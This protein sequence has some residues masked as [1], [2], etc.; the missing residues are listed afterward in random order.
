MIDDAPKIQIDQPLRRARV[1]QVAALTGVSTGFLVDALGGA[2]A[3]DYRI[4]PVVPE[5]GTF[6]GSALV[7]NAGPADNLAIFAALDSLQAGEV[8]VA[9]TGSHIACAVTGDLLLGMARNSGAVAFVTDGCVRDVPGIRQVGLPCFATG[10]TP[11]SPARTG[12][13]TVGFAVVVG[14]VTVANGDIVAGDQDGVVVVPYER[15]D[16]C[17]ERLVRVRAAEAELDAKVKAGLKST[18]WNH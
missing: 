10:V 3:L 16:D 4:K 1:E 14:G 12:P 5:Q 15:I 17:I 6:C 13:G 7:C 18:P 11:N 8:I 9:A 2:G